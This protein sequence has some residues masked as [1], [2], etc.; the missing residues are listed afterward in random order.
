MNADEHRYKKAFR[1]KNPQPLN[2]SKLTA[3]DSEL[4][5]FRK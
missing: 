1:F 5:D 3:Y 4:R 2:N